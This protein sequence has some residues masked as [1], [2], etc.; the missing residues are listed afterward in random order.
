[1]KNYSDIISY[2]IIGDGYAI[3][4]NDKCVFMITTSDFP[5]DGETVED[6]CI[7][8]IKAEFCKADKESILDDI[9]AEILLGQAEIIANQTAQDE[10]LAEVLLNSLEV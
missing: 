10:V 8:H 3:Y 6:A 5:Y 1:M 4:E 9:L 7:N 2:D